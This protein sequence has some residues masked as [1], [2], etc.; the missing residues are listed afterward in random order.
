MPLPKISTSQHELTLPSTGKTIKF[1]PFLVREEKILILALE[2]QNPK[3]ISNAVKQVLKDCIITR[4]IKVD[5]LPSFDIEYIFLNVRGKS[6]GEQ[7]EIIVTC[8]DDGET[9]VPAFINIDE[10]EVK[11]DPN[12]SQEIQLGEGYTLKMKYPSLNQFLEDNFSDDE[13]DGG[14]EKSF[15]IIASSID[16]VY[17]DDNVWAAKECTKKELVEW[18][19]SLTSEQFK[20]IENFFE[21]MPKLTHD[22][23]VTN[24]KTGKDNPVTLEG[25]SDFFA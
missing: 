18:L 21:T 22:I 16:M 15:Q 6:V 9:Q 8:G 1:R 3:Q 14:V 2:S 13:D 10:V 5:T 23:V 24:P 4:G 17:S 12:H 11:T 20:K 25:L 19:E 7:I